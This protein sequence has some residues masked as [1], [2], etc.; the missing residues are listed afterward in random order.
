MH[1]KESGYLEQRIY[2]SL[3]YNCNLIY[4]SMEKD[5]NSRAKWSM[6]NKKI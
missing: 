5:G 1:L 4:P 6:K 2:L 3:L